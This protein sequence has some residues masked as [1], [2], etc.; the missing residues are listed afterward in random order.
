MWQ[1]VDVPEQQP[2]QVAHRAQVCPTQPV[3]K[4][5]P[6]THTMGAVMSLQKKMYLS[7]GVS[8]TN[9]ITIQFVEQSTRIQNKTSTLSNI[10]QFFFFFL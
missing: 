7:L 6:I 2:A 5:Q 3:S 10:L 9:V 4:L 8:S 1:H